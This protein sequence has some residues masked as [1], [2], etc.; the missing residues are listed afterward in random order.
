M[1]TDFLRN[2][3]FVINQREDVGVGIHVAQG[4]D[5]LFAPTHGDQPVVDDGDTQDGSPGFALRDIA[6]KRH[7]GARRQYG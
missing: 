1:P 2:P 7:A 4:F 3:F 6:L 5:D